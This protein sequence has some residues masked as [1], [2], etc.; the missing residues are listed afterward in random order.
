MTRTFIPH[1]CHKTIGVLGAVSVATACLLTAA[2]AAE[3][4][5]VPG[6]NSKTV[7]IEHPGGSFRVQL[8][9]DNTDNNISAG[10][11]RTARLIFKGDIFV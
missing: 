6:G 3:I 8:D 10:V 7:D 1:R 5:N 2:P 4:A 9:F 11:I